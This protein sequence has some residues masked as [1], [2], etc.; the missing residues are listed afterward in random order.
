MSREYI[1]R[2]LKTIL[3]KLKSKFSEQMLELVDSF[4]ENGCALVHYVTALNYH[5][6][7]PILNEYGANM[8]LKTFSKID[9]LTPLM[10]AAAKGH[11]KTV[12]KLMRVGASLFHQVSMKIPSS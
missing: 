1:K 10:I 6:L 4:D 9:Q 7:I 11:E 8:S 3:E 5:E 12:K 2:L